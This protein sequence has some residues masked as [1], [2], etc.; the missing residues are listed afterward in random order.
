MGGAV[1]GKRGAGAEEGGRA[2]SAAS[3]ALPDKQH[4]PHPAPSPQALTR[5][6]HGNVSSLAY[7][8]TAGTPTSQ[9]KSQMHPY[10]HSPTVAGLL[11]GAGKP[12]HLGHFTPQEATSGSPQDTAGSLGPSLGQP[13]A[14]GA[15]ETGG[16]QSPAQIDRTPR[17]SKAEFWSPGLSDCGTKWLPQPGL[18]AA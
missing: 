3:P 15:G 2:G 17:A 8:L 7:S 11:L 14:V 6:S 5:P 16:T 9:H 13:Q 1:W 4:W 12:V 18:A 10:G